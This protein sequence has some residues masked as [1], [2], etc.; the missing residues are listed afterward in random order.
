MTP[1]DKSFENYE[2]LSS[3]FQAL[4]SSFHIANGIDVTDEQDTATEAKLTVNW[5][6]T[7]TDFGTGQQ[8]TTQRR[9]KHPAPVETRKVEDC[10]FLPD[11]AVQSTAEADFKIDSKW[12]AYGFRR[13][14][15]S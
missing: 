2:K 13:L 12:S 9:R 4:T 15:G 8:R 5:T 14:F 3:Y 6:L 1:F 7:L 11:L 10:R